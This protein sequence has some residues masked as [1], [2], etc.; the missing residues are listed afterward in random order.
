MCATP[1]SASRVR[2][3]EVIGS[4]I[5]EG[6]FG[7]VFTRLPPTDPAEHDAAPYRAAAAGTTAPIGRATAMQLCGLG[8]HP[9][10][11]MCHHRGGGAPAER[12]RA[13]CPPRGRI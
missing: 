10:H 6:G 5:R 8:D 2:I 13:H 3:K 4:L 1:P 7:S 9:P 11:L 12:A